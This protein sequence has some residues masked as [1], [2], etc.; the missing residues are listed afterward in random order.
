MAQWFRFRV[1]ARLRLRKQAAGN[2]TARAPDRPQ[3]SQQSRLARHSAAPEKPGNAF[4]P[5]DRTNAGGGSSCPY[6]RYRGGRGTLPAGDDAK[7]S[8]NPDDGGAAR[9][10]AG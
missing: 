7:S 5:G 1:D 8:R 9:L 4:T 3:L 10:Q 6:R 2:D